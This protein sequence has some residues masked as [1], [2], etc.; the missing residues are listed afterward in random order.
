MI[1]DHV[2]HA[3]SQV[4]AEASQEGWLLSRTDPPLSHDEVADRLTNYLA[5]AG[6]IICPGHPID[7]LK[8]FSC[9]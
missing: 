9:L 7:L 6:F 1:H 4:L 5:K 2:R 3:L 8:H